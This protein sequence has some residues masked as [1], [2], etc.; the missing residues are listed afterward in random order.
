MRTVFR[1]DCF[2]ASILVSLVGPT[3]GL[4][5]L[6]GTFSETNES[7]LA[8]FTSYALAF[9]SQFQALVDTYDVCAFECLGLTSTHASFG[10]KLRRDMHHIRRHNICITFQPLVD[11]CGV[12]PFQDSLRVSSRACLLPSAAGHAEW[13][14]QLLCGGAGTARAGVSAP[15]QIPLC[16]CQSLT[17]AFVTCICDITDA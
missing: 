7:E 6:Q 17:L 4:A 1:R 8:S 14:P 13:R 3:Q 12:R 2:L 10:Y 5:A 15:C 9:P 11:S 16:P